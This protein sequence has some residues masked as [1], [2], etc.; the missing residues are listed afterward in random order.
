[1]KQYIFRRVL[2]SLLVLVGISFLLYAILR[3]MPG[4]FITATTSGNPGITEEMKEKLKAL[5]GLDKNIVSGYIDWVK[6]ALQLDLGTS[7][8]YQK[9]VIDVIKDKM[10]VSFSL[11]AIAFVLQLLL[12]IP[13]GT[14]AA[15]K[16]YS[17]TDYTIVAIA[18]AGISLPSFFFAAVLQRIFEMGLGIL[19][20]KGMVNERK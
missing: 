18:L 1:M 3:L 14:I 8:V 17:K 5:Y 12:A 16:Q 15:T 6:G 13:L 4:D 9:P 7:F 19:P 10:W 11:S 2:I 20:F